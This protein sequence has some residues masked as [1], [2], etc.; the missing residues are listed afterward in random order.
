MK[1]NRQWKK[2]LLGMLLA[3]AMVLTQV[4]VWNAGIESVQAAEKDSLRCITTMRAKS[5]CM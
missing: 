1:E 3:F 4:G 5:R 2:R